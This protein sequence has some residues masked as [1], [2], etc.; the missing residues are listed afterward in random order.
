MTRKGKHAECVQNF[1]QLLNS[2]LTLG[3][4][5]KRKK[6]LKI[7]AVSSIPRGGNWF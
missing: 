4:G 3:E 5:E 2:S 1:I 7:G 6:G